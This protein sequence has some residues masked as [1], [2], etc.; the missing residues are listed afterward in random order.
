MQKSSVVG[1]ALCLSVV[2]STCMAASDSGGNVGPQRA[3][4][5][6]Q[7]ANPGTGTGSTVTSNQANQ[8]YPTGSTQPDATNH[9]RNQPSGGG[10]N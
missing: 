10:K 1:L 9:N 5:T 7:V 3:T 4:L 6:P 2:A 8:S